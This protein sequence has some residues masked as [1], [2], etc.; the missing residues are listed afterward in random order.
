MAAKNSA[1]AVDDVALDLQRR[2]H[3]SAGLGQ[4]AVEDREALDLLDPSELP[5][6]RID[7]AWIAAWTRS[8]LAIV[9]RS[10]DPEMAGK[11]GALFAVERDQGD[12]VR[13]VVP[14]DDRLGDPALFTQL[15]L[16]VRPG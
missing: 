16:D 2:C 8:S 7:M 4:L 11:L 9:A 15:A 12:K 10:R 13:A 1:Y 3:L 5:V 6:D 14:V